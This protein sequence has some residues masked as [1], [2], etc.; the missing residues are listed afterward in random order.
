VACVAAGGA[1]ELLSS[2]IYFNH[3]GA[4]RS[5]GGPAPRAAWRSIA[6]PWEAVRARILSGSCSH[7]R[8]PCLLRTVY[9][10]RRLCII[11]PYSLLTLGSS[12]RYSALP[13][14]RAP[15]IVFT[16]RIVHAASRAAAAVR[17]HLLCP[18]DPSRRPT[19]VVAFG[20]TLRRSQ[21]LSPHLVFTRLP[22]NFLPHAP[23]PH[24]SD[25]VFS[26]RPVASRFWL[27]TGF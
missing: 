1:G 13:D 14:C 10:A 22:P 25:G 27:G 7:L 11:T 8:P 24:A 9:C 23:L 5:C 21:P 15:M 3:V 26:H 2:V 19:P 18:S 4:E 6:G 12:A 20:S 17:V 16:R